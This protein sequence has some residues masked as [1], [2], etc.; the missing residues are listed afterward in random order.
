MKLFLV[1]LGLA[2]GQETAVSG[3]EEA[4][5]AVAARPTIVL[6]HGA[7]VS[8]DSWEPVQKRYEER[9]YTVMAP[10][11]PFE[12]SVGAVVSEGDPFVSLGVAQIADEYQ[13]SI[14][15]IE[16][17]VVLIGHSF[18]GLI[19]QVLLDRGVGDVGVAISPAPSKGIVPSLRAAATILPFVR[20]KK[21]GRVP[22]AIS[23]KQFGRNFANGIDADD[24]D[25]GYRKYVIPA[26]GRLFWEA[27]FRPIK[28]NFRNPNR[29][30]LL[31]IAGEQ[32]RVITK[33]MVRATYRRQL[34]A[35]AATEWR[36]VPGSHALIVA[37]G[38]EKL[39]DESLEWALANLGEGQI[40][41]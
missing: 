38:W 23:R 16:G 41:K 2:W 26:P 9:G 34:R 37:E 29:A 8:A 39:A 4:S 22:S 17:P 18:G 40:V 20:L 13:R 7:W 25:E 33:G 36:V 21:G 10:R 11:W 3:P 35:G 12:P 30:P 6:I 24:V 1:W 15:G 32:D 28:V 27:T 19:V 14:E 31:L 5:I